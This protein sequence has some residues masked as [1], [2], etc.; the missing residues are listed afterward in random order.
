MESGLLTRILRKLP[1]VIL[2]VIDQLLFAISGLALTF[3]AIGY[4]ERDAARLFVIAFACAQSYVPIHNTLVNLTLSSFAPAMTAARK[5]GYGVFSFRLIIMTAALHG[6]AVTALV[7]VLFRNEVVAFDQV[8]SIFFFAILTGIFNFQR[9]WFFQDMRFDLALLL[10]LLA[11]VLVVGALVSVQ[12]R[13]GSTDWSIPVWAAVFARGVSIAVFFRCLPRGRGAQGQIR[14]GFVAKHFQVGKWTMLLAGANYLRLNGIY[15]LLD[16]VMG[17]GGLLLLKA[18]DT[19][20]GPVRQ[21][22]GGII[23]YLVP[24]ISKSGIK[25][26]G[27]RKILIAAGAVGAVG[28]VTFW[29]ISLTPVVDIL[30]PRFVTALAMAAPVIG[31]MIFTHFLSAACI[32][33]LRGRSEFPRLARAMFIASTLAAC[34]VIAGI[35]A[36]GEWRIGLIGFI[37]VDLIFITIAALWKKAPQKLRSV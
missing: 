6:T 13:G 2:S 31:L 4:M 22:S 5:Q 23:S 10:D 29:L 8:I 3:Y 26:G 30:P 27:I 16:S 36:T 14:R 21:I 37:A 15:I 12:M 1:R 17:A 28:G 7:W 11:A 20:Q 33:I 34:A 19:L 9:Y 25:A 32:G 18:A 35:A 24:N